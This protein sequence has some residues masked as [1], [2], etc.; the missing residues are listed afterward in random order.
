VTKIAGSGSES[1]SGSMR[2]S[3]WSA[4]L[5]PDPHQN[6]MD[7]EHCVKP[8]V[9]FCKVC[10]LVCWGRVPQVAGL[11]RH[12]GGICNTTP[13]TQV[14]RSRCLKKG[15]SHEMRLEFCWHVCGTVEREEDMNWTA[16]IGFPRYD[17]K[18]CPISHCINYLSACQIVLSSLIL[19]LNTT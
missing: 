14:F 19:T 9:C 5:D 18:T 16:I 3:H 6:I 10:Q 1:G 4:D 7:P 11:L 2:E 15:L 12:S 13:R 17:L 8:H